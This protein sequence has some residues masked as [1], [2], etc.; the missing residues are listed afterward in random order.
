M[1]GREPAY[2][3]ILNG[4]TAIGV[5]T[6]VKCFEQGNV[7]F[8]LMTT[9]SANA[10]IKIQGSISPHA[11]N[12]AEAASPTNSWF[13]VQAAYL[14]SGVTITGSTGIV[15]TGTDVAVGVNVNMELL[16]YVN[17]N[18]TAHSAGTIHA[19]ARLANNS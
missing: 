10:T 17:L 8:D 19:R 13:Y 5:G 6:A 11:P 15:L 1:T 3:T 12:F 4:V 7:V 18:V 9:G 16:S 2:T 14:D